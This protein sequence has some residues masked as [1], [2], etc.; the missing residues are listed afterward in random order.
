M[1]SSLVATG[2]ETG[3]IRFKLRIQPP[4]AG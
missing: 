4:A 2:G 3:I 1:E